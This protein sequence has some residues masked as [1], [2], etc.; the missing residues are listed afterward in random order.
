MK[1]LR[2][3]CLGLPDTTE[4]FTFGHPCFRVAN[5]MFAVLEEYKGELG[6][7]FTVGKLMQGVFLDDPR[8]FRTP[9]VGRYGWVTLRVHAAKLD[10]NE[11]RELVKG[12]YALVA[13]SKKAQKRKT[14][15]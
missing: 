6:I 9:Y 1:R 4:T 7:C 2:K 5:K 3:I 15:R 14:A 11:I 8:F 13:S 12:S 10:W